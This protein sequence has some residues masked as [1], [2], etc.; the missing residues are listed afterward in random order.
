MLRAA[1]ILAGVLLFALPVSADVIVLKSGRRISA[2]NVVEEGERVSY[3][4]SAGRLS[5]RKELVERVERGAVAPGTFAAAV[6]A[7]VEFQS[8]RP[9][10]LGEGYEEVMRATV[11]AGAV[12]RDYIARL[13]EEAKRGGAEPV[14]RVLMA[15]RAASEFLLGQKDVDEAIRYTQRAFQF[16]PEHAGFLEQVAY[17]HLLKGEYTQALD[18]LERARRRA[19][20]SANVAKLTGWAY[21]GQNRVEQAVGEWQR[22]Y[23][24][25]PDPDVKQ[26]L[27]KAE[28]DKETE[29]NYRAGETRHFTLRYHGEAAPELARDV[30]RALEGDFAEI[31]N[32]LGYTPREPI[33]V[34]LYTAEVF[35]DIT[36]APSWVGAVNDGR[37]RVPVQGLTG[38]TPRLARVLKHELAHSFIRLKS[39]GNAPVW[40]HEGIAQW[41]EGERSGAAAAM[42]VAAYE[43]NAHLSLADLESSFLGKSDTVAE[44]AYAWSLAVVEYIAQSGGLSDID[45]ILERIGAG[46]STESALRSTL[47]LGYPEIEEETIKYLRRTYLR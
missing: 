42:L 6:E 32:A 5:I 27:E 39:R 36:R 11:G 44:F 7:P 29:S 46:S 8:S 45:R 41:L 47:R 19:P 38:V 20:D 17:L 28:R 2:T 16:A 30:L 15:Y 35:T 10:E 14:R 18:S 1:K 22:A 3:E 9:V 24:L 37:I 21:Y 12:D 34:I 26:A 4:T 43:K 33:G 40:L 13:E 23:S 31:E 25:R